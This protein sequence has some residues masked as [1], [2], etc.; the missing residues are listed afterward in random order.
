MITSFLISTEIDFC[1]RTILVVL[2]PSISHYTETVDK[3]FF[4]DIEMRSFENIFQIHCEEAIKAL[5]ED[6]RKFRSIY[7]ITLYEDSQA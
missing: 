1:G 4:G 5:R 3:S 2:D 6:N 7:R